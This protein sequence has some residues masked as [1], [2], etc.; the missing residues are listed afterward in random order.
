MNPI[1][2]LLGVIP[3]LLISILLFIIVSIVI[4]YVITIGN[5]IN[6]NYEIE[7]KDAYKEYIKYKFDISVI[8]LLCGLAGALINYN[9]L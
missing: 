7:F 6:G 2:F 8:A 3:G 9:Y 1:E 4:C 5:I